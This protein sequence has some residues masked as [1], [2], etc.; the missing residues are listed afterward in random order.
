MI[1][2]FIFVS[3]IVDILNRLLIVLVRA[4]TCIALIG[5]SITQGRL[6]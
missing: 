6:L 5:S 3:N 4:F 1:L 2:Q